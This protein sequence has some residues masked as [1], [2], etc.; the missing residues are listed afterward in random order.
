MRRHRLLHIV[1]IESEFFRLHH[2][3]STSTPSSSARSFFPPISRSATMLPTAG[4]V[5]STPSATHAATTLCAVFGFTFSAWLS[6]RTEGNL[7][8]GRSYRVTTAFRTANMI[9]SATGSPGL[10][11]TENGSTLFSSH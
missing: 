3:H 5:T 8:P 2:E 7:S 9:C 6:T 1:E 10:S 4:V 11:S